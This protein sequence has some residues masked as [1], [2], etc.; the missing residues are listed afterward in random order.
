MYCYIY[1]IG[2]EGGDA[3]T[4]SPRGTSFLAS[5]R[6]A[7]ITS[8]LCVYPYRV[9]PS[10]KR[11]CVGRLGVLSYSKLM[12]PNTTQRGLEG[13]AHSTLLESGVS[14]KTCPF[15]G[16]TIKEGEH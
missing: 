16:G 1:L 15:V 7:Q 12:R 5:G 9:T 8:D 6:K 3:E 13:D 11:R 10:N 4:K 2:K 14:L